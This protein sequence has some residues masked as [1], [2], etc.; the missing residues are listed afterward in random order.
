MNFERCED[1]NLFCVKAIKSDAQF[2]LGMHNMQLK[3]YCDYFDI[4]LNYES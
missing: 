4:I 3:S 1:V 2:R